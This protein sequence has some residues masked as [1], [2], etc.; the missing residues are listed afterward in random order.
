MASNGKKTCRTCCI[1]LL[2]LLVLLVVAGC[3]AM[4][5][6][7][8]GET[9]VRRVSKGGEVTAAYDRLDAEEKTVSDGAYLVAGVLLSLYAENQGIEDGTAD[10]YVTG[11]A[12]YKSQ[13]PDEGQTPS[14]DGVVLYAKDIKTAW[15]IMIAYYQEINKGEVD[16]DKTETIVIARGN[17]VYCGTVKGATLLFTKAFF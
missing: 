10:E 16:T 17:A 4:L 7:P 13:T 9:L 5:Y 14:I 1:I 8:T 11:I 15:D 6:M 12:E 3:L 2:V